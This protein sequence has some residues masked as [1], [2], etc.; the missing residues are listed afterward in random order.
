MKPKLPI[1][2]H[3][4]QS[5]AIVPMDYHEVSSKMLQ[6]KKHIVRELFCRTSFFPP[7]KE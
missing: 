2:V 5:R 1:I 4:I 6:T 7:I 3:K